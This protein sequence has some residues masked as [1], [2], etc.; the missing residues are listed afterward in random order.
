MV[1]RKG[2]KDTFTE[3]NSIRHGPRYEVDHSVEKIRTSAAGRRSAAHVRG[4]YVSGNN[5]SK[6]WRWALFYEVGM[7]VGSY[8]V[9]CYL[10]FFID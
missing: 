3:T 1:F 2:K 9:L 6:D 10:V 4:I 7:A 8:L 5:Y